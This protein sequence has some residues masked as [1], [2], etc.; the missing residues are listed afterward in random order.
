MARRSAVPELALTNR[1]A[2][3]TGVPHITKRGASVISALV[4]VLN[5][6]RPKASRSVSPY[7][8]GAWRGAGR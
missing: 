1:A 5:E 2:T 8:A 3:M 6:Q 4:R 7:R